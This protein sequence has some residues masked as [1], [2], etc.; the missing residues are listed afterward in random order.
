MQPGYPSI[1][2]LILKIPESSLPVGPIGA[3]ASIVE[4]P[5][6]QV[7]SSSSEGDDHDIRSEPAPHDVSKFSHETEEEMQAATPERTLPSRE[8][9]TTKG[10]LTFLPMAPLI[11]YIVDILMPAWI[12]F[13][14]GYRNR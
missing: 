5:L 4:A 6:V 10:I 14:K 13:C 9:A 11:G 8:T 3:K 2:M 1:M 12:T 7:L